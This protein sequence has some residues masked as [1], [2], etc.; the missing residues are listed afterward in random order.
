M[1]KNNNKAS[2]DQ[3]L[4]PG[5]PSGTTKQN[6]DNDNFT[7]VSYK[8]KGQPA[9]TATGT[10]TTTTRATAAAK[11]NDAILVTLAT[12]ATFHYRVFPILE[13]IAN[14]QELQNNPFVQKCRKATTQGSNKVT[15]T[16]TFRVI[17]KALQLNPPDIGAYRSLLQTCPTIDKYIIFMQA[18]QGTNG[19]LYKLTSSDE[20]TATNTGTALDDQTLVTTQDIETI[21]ST[22]YSDTKD[23]SFTTCYSNNGDF[24]LM[25]TTFWPSIQT[26]IA[27]NPSHEHAKQWTTWME[28]GVNQFADLAFVKSIL[29]TETLDQ[30]FIIFRNSPALQ[31]DFELVWDHKI[32]YRPK[33]Q[34]Q[35]IVTPHRSNMSNDHQ[36]TT[37]PDTIHNSVMANVIDHPIDFNIFHKKLHTLIDHWAHLPMARQEATWIVWQKWTWK[38][39]KSTSTFTEL[40]KIMD[41]TSLQDYVKKMSAFPCFSTPMFRS[42]TGYNFP[43][44]RRSLTRRTAEGPGVHSPQQK[45]YSFSTIAN[46]K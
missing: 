40:T 41:I 28:Q 3:Q 35:S 37:S 44:V 20:S 9:R 36:T 8:K 33:R 22:S 17:A 12:F 21:D 29:G 45:K 31:D 13:Q 32:N 6:V 46:D 18:T 43:A 5:R 15:A 24:H 16:S 2:E 4:S 38:G 26:F 27:N 23:D 19:F 42:G 11:I 25:M 10:S 30:L 7:M 39:I 34:T 14:Q 1:T